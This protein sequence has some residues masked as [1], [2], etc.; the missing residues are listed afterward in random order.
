MGDLRDAVTAYLE[1]ERAKDTEREKLRTLQP[2]E[3]PWQG[4]HAALLVAAARVHSSRVALLV[5]LAQPADTGWRDRPPT[6]AE[7]IAHHAAHPITEAGAEPA[8]WWWRWRSDVRPPEIVAV[9]WSGFDLCMGGIPVRR[10]GEMPAARWLPLT[11]GAV[12]APWP[13][14][15]RE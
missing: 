4:S 5:A 9:Y 8:S 12:P 13:E 14:V 1:A 3:P 10:L 2:V 11:A 7:V 6:E 15:T